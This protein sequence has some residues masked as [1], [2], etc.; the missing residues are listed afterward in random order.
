MLDSLLDWLIHLPFPL[1]APTPWAT[2][3]SVRGL[4][5]HNRRGG[6]NTILLF[7][8]SHPFE[9][10]TVYPSFLVAYDTLTMWLINHF[11]YLFIRFPP[12]LFLSIRFVW[13][14]CLRFFG[15]NPLL[16]FA[17]CWLLGR[18]SCFFL[19]ITN[20]HCLYKLIPCGQSNIAS[21][22]LS[23]K[24]CK[25]LIAHMGF[26]MTFCS[27]HIAPLFITC[28]ECHK[29]LWITIFTQSAE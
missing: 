11:W 21:I 13:I 5:E 25:T 28:P 2:S 24:V 17:W 14:W 8:S 18:V 19:C 29:H 6:C 22:V 12:F 20:R 26:S 4:T 7:S 10:W 27:I 23:Y 9:V 15:R 16:S 3:Y 1:G